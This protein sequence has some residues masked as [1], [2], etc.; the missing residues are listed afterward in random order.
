M[1][2]IKRFKASKK[3]RRTSCNSSEKCVLL[4]SRKRHSLLGS[5][6]L[7]PNS[8]ALSKNK[9]LVF[10]LVALEMALPCNYLLYQ[11]CCH[12]KVD[13]N[14][15]HVC[16]DERLQRKSACYAGDCAGSA[17]PSV[18]SKAFRVLMSSVLYKHECGSHQQETCSQSD[19]NPGI[20]SSLIGGDC[21]TFVFWNT[22]R[23]VTPYSLLIPS[24]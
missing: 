9:V 14:A 5:S 12:N 23:G 1:R 3:I 8:D 18:K 16:R 24:S 7:E 22:N 20:R 11:F 2:L 15:P 13:H 4:I 21:S 10:Y 19:L 6:K 17:S